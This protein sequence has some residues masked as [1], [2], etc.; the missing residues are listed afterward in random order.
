VV[1]PGRAASA[2]PAGLVT[3]SSMAA[4]PPRQRRP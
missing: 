3:L 1:T 2:G 4:S